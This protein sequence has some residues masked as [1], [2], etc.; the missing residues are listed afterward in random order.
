[1]HAVIFD[2]D[3]TPGRPHLGR[4]DGQHRV[5]SGQRTGR[6]RRGDRAHT[7]GDRNPALPRLPAA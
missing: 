1:M 5:G 4:P 3:D 2:L 6:Q 7:V